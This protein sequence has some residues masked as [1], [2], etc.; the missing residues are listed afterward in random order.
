MIAQMP[1]WG[2]L[3]PLQRHVHPYAKSTTQRLRKTYWR[4]GL[5]WNFDH[6]GDV[7]YNLP[8]IADWLATGGGASHE[9][10]CEQYLNS[11]PSNQPKTAKTPKTVT[12]V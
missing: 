11:L 8:L 3:A 5:H 7:I 9:R 2:K 1:N 4:E 12:A 10:A 6:A